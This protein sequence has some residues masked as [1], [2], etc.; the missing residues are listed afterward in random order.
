DA[1]GVGPAHGRE[2]VRATM[3]VRAQ[4]LA[5]GRSGVRPVVVD[6]LIAMLNAGILPVVPEI[7]SVGAS[8]DLVEL[9][10]VARALAGEG[11]VDWDGQRVDAAVALARAGLAPVTFEGREALALMNGT[12][13]EAAQAALVGVGAERLGGAGEAGA[14]RG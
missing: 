8:G 9:A 7:G 2:V 1:S 3:A 4:T 6:S 5:Q 13:C 10:H 12:S 11:A 14:G